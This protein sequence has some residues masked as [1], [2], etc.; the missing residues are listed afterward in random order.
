MTQRLQRGGVHVAHGVKELLEETAT[1]LGEGHP[2][3]ARFD[4][5]Y[6]RKEVV[7][8][9]SA[10]GWDYSISVTSETYK[11]PLRE[12]ISDFCEDDWEALNEDGSEHAAFIY[13]RPG[14]RKGEQVYVVVRS[15]YRGS[16]KLLGIHLFWLAGTILHLRR[17]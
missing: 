10:R 11:R 3:W 16:Q 13:H 17:S 8:F 15:M 4:N 2:V 1:V 12:M 6:Y 9:C 7:E 5:A 14:G